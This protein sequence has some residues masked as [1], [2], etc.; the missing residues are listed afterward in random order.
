LRYHSF[1]HGFA[2]AG[3]RRKDLDAH[4]APELISGDSRLT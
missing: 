2:D 1:V 3:Y 4:G